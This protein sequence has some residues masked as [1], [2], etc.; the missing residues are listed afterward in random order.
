MFD[1]Q[2]PWILV[3]DSVWLRTKVAHATFHYGKFDD[4]Q[5]DVTTL[6]TATT[7]KTTTFHTFE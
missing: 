4:D 3:G 7:T 1:L 6:K 2:E 5:D